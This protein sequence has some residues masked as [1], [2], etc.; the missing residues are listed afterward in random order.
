MSLDYFVIPLTE[1]PSQDLST[2]LAGQVCRMVVYAK[3]VMAPILLPEMI[4]TD[5]PVYQ[6]VCPVYLDLYLTPAGGGAE[7]L[8]VGGVVAHHATRIVRDTY[9]GFVGD[10][11]FYDTQGE[12]DPFGVPR[13]LPPY[14]LQNPYQ[15]A[16]PRIAGNRPSNPNILGVC[17]GLGTRFILTYWPDLT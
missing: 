9:L 17:P 4:A 12:E 13:R 7:E 11:A 3:S 8:V 1:A 14:Y 5:P 2:T 16:L 15:M 6:N 10:L